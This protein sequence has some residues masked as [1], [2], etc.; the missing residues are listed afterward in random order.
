MEAITRGFSGPKT[1]AGIL[2]YPRY[3]YD[4]GIG[5]K[6]AMIPELLSEGLSAVDSSL[7]NGDMKM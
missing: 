4:A 2:V 5:L 3:L 7:G 1:S 6:R